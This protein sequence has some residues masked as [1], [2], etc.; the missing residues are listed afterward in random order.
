MLYVKRGQ[1]R[2]QKPL[3]MERESEFTVLC[4]KEDNKISLS[5]F[6]IQKRHSWVI[7]YSF[8]HGENERKVV[9]SLQKGIEIIGRARGNRVL[10]TVISP[11]WSNG[12]NFAPANMSVRFLENARIDKRLFAAGAVTVGKLDFKNATRVDSLGKIMVSIQLSKDAKAGVYSGMIT[13][14]LD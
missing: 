12:T 4:D 1:K 3:E 2:M 11:T 7:T 13:I 6:E 14:T 10:F 9:Y 8:E 5:V